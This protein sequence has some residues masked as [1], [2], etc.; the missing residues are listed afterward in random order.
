V[1]EVEETRSVGNLV[2]VSLIWNSDC[3]SSLTLL[4]KVA[5]LG[6]RFF[7]SGTDI[8]LRTMSMSYCS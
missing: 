4:V 7:V 6:L 2:S 5:E 3:S 1:L 8:V